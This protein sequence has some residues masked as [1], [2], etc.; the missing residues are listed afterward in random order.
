MLLSKTIEKRDEMESGVRGWRC[1]A[2]VKGG[3]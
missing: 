2:M 3:L 1:G